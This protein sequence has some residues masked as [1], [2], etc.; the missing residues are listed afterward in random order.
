M[1]AIR[2]ST[3]AAASSSGVFDAGV[4]DLR[5]QLGDVV[6]LVAVLGRLLAA[7]AGEDRLAEPLDLAAAVVEVVLA[8]DRVA[9]RARGSARAR[10]RTPRGGRTRPSAGR[11]G[12]PRRTRPGRARRARRAPNASPAASTSSTAAR[13]QASVRNRLRKPGPATSTR[14]TRAAEPVLQRRAEP[15]GDRARRLAQRGREQHR[16]VRRVVAEAG[17][18]RPLE[19]QPVAGGGAAVAQ[20]AGRLLDGGLEVVEWRRHEG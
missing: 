12:W 8:L 14:S 7:R 20:L 4:R 13:Y 2:I 10:R 19:A 16:R 18:L 1:R 15:L 3:P 17:L 6:A 5:G 11:S 9:V